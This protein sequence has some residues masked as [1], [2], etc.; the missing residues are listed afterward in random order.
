[1][2]MQNPVAM[3]TGGITIF[4]RVTAV[5]PSRT[6]QAS[7]PARPARETTAVRTGVATMNFAFQFLLRAGWIRF[8]AHKGQSQ[9]GTILIL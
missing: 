8:P 7:T 1:M 2:N 5:R 3:P 6:R 4:F 9:I